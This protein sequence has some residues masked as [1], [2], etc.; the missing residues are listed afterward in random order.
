MTRSGFPSLFTS[1]T[2]KRPVSNG[3]RKGV[4]TGTKVLFDWPKETTICIPDTLMMSMRPSR[5]KSAT[6]GE[7]FAT[8]TGAEKMPFPR[9]KATDCVAEE[10]VFGACRRDLNP[11][12]HR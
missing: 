2:L 9:L 11:V 12:C 6:I 8:A 7:L 3:R 5:L 4:G 1:P 10:D